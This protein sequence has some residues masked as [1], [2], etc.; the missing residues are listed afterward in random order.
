MEGN[1]NAQNH[2]ACA[3]NR[4]SLQSWRVARVL[5]MLG[6][7]ENETDLSDT[8]PVPLV[9]DLDGTLIRTD[10]LYE[11]FWNAGINGARH[12]VEVLRQYRNG[13]AQ[14]KRYLANAASID[15]ATLPYDQAV[16]DFIAR[17]RSEGR[18]VYLATASDSKHAEGVAAHLDL[19]DGV[20]ASDG[21]RNLDGERKAEALVSAFG[22]GGFDYMAD[23]KVDMAV[24]A[25]AR[26]AITVR[27]DLDSVARLKATHTS[28]EHVDAGK[29]VGVKDWLRALRVHQYAKN[30]LIFVPM[31]TGQAYS[32]QSL[33]LALLAFVAFSLCASSVYLVNDLLD[34]QADRAH[35]NKRLRPL[36]AGTVP[37][38]AAMVAAPLLL[39]VAFATAFAVSPPFVGVLLSYLVLT[40][41]YSF[42][43]KRKMMIDVVALAGLY[44]VRIFGGAVAISIIVSEWLLA[45]SMFAFLSLALIKRYSELSV[46]LDRNMSDPTNRNYKI[47]DLVIIAALA[48]AAAMNAVT[49]FTLYVAS[50]AV[51]DAYSRPQLLYLVAPVLLY[52]FCRAILMTHRRLMHDDPVVFA[53]K[54]RNSRYAGVILLL[55]VL[56][57]N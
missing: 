14:L 55:I 28:V 21:E 11:T 24:W 38:R 56:V 15:Y 41:T 30:A 1:L 27:L 26:N 6:T 42:Y 40:T 9:V 32:I 7:S 19:F 4:D 8:T 20:F 49:V 34:L 52:W 35:P 3:E 50:P 10:L 44:T 53:L 16:I 18:K 17:A 45:F 23:H 33:V 29:S 54:D 43:L 31:L 51:Q 37:I 2:C 25:R 22:D 46:R 13:R 39:L 47:G 36:A 5:A 48:A 57:A 12:Y